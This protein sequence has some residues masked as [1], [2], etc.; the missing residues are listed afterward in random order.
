MGITRRRFIQGSAAGAFLGSG[1]FGSPW[2][3]QALADTIGNRYLISVF[4]DGGNDGLNTVT[5]IDDGAGT[6]RTDYDGHRSSINLSP[7]ALLPL[8]ATDP[9]TGANL[10]LHPGLGGPTGTGGIKALWDLGKVAILQGCGYPDYGLSHDGSRRVWETANPLGVTTLGGSGWVGRHLADCYGS[11]DIRAVAVQDAIPQSFRQSVTGVLSLLRLDRFSFPYDEEEASD[12][13]ARRAAFVQLS[14]EASASA[15]DKLAFIGNGGAAT[16]LASEAYPD[17]AN[18]YTPSRLEALNSQRNRMARDF[19]EIARIING[20]ESGIP[21]VNARFFQARNAGYDTH[22]GQGGAQAG[23]RHTLL[24]RQVGDA[25]EAFYLD[26]ADLN[27]ALPD[28]ICILVWS[29]FSRRIPQNGNG[30]DH[31]SQGPIFLIGGKVAGGIYGDHP[32]IDPA[33]LDNQGNTPYYQGATSGGLVRSLD[34]RDVYGSVLKQWVN[35]P[36][37]TIL[38]DLLPLDTPNPS[39]KYW[40]VENFDLPVFVP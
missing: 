28:K 35:L 30:T 13:A 5:P 16:L 31:G 3:R 14:L 23:G 20:V 40:Q 38:S 22:S 15:Q 33:M 25:L 18:L 27:P 19:R 6:L 8:L 37:S 9:N 34:F 24:H 12:I 7:G 11:T 32:N 36:H 26:L 4:L 2:V 1:I 21:N 17:L 29:E 39:T 10:G